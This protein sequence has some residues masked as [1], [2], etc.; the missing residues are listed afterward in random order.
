MHCIVLNK[1]L[2][3]PVHRKRELVG[4]SVIH[5]ISE[6]MTTK[7][8]FILI[9]ALL[10][11]GQTLSQVRSGEDVVIDDVVNGDLYIAG[12]TVTIN[13][14]ILGD[15]IVAGGTIVVSDSVSQ[16]LLAAGGDITINGFVGDDIRSAGGK[17][18]LSSEVA[19]DFVVAGGE[20][21][22]DKQSI[23]QGNLLSAGGKTTLDGTV[24]GNIW[25]ASGRFTLNGIVEQDIDCRGGE[26]TINGSVSGNARL[27][28][29]AIELGPN[30]IFKKEVRYWN[31]DKQLDF[32]DAVQG[33][34]VAFDPSLEINDGR[35][36]YLGFAT[37]LMAAW[38]L[39]TALVM[40][41][42]IQYLFGKALR[43]A[44]DTVKNASL[45][46]LGLGLLFLVGVPVS[47]VILFITVIGIPLGILTIVAYITL[48]L[49]A[50]I[51]VSLVISNWL[52]NT[53]YR[54]SW[55]NGRTVLTAFAI[56]IFLKLASLTPVTG[57][58]IMLLLVCMAFGGILQ[59]I[60]WK[61]N[62]RTALDRS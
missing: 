6:L 3:H 20:I 53:Y 18:R 32:G 56:F 5:N 34:K 33:G 17:V 42:F 23:I 15:L 60:K 54:S 28:A 48:L 58:F 30:A 55:G 12:G 21:R 35:W 44:A 61:K 22:I 25:G 24:K 38:Y 51:I 14:P 52:N 13:A 8:L 11:A 46:S 49:L 45:K 1:K 43:K 7:S 36:H 59:N 19:G 16:D 31:E 26:I 27:A 29:N 4:V 39:G 62:N 10:V 40:I 41:L 57:P 9:P 37:F 2:L 47:I 50:T